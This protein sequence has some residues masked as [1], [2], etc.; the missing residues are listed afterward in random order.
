[1]NAVPKFVASR[2]LHE[3]EWNAEIL[4]GDLAGAVA[5]LKAQAGQD[6]LIYGSGDLV[7][8][9][10]RLGLIDEYRL[11]IH[12]VVVGSCKRLFATGAETTLRL[13]GSTTTETGVVVLAY[14]ADRS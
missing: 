14:A 3:G 11:M 10:T 7:D 8:E 12:P 4:K 2:T 1:M 9:L 5:G 6:L 13:V